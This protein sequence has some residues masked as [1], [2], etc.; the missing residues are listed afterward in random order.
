MKIDNGKRKR[1]KSSNKLVHKENFDKD[2]R[3]NMAIFVVY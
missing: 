2:Q 1:N 3:V